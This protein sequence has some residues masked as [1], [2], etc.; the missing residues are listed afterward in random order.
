MKLWPEGAPGAMKAPSSQAPANPNVVTNI[1]DPTISIYRPEKSNG[2]AVIVAPGGGYRFLSI[3]N[4]GTAVCEWLN[5]IGV[6]AALLTYRTP[7]NEEAVPFEKPVR[8]RSVRLESSGIMLR[9]G[10]SHGLVYSDFPQGTSRGMSLWIARSEL[11]RKN[12]S[13]MAT[14]DRT[15]W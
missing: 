13:R 9:N 5:S 11:I 8:M 7:T 4:E 12:R 2:T 3:K 10:V 1:T 6:T 14:R 15:S